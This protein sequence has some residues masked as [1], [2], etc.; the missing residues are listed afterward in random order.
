MLICL[1]NSPVWEPFVLVNLQTPKLCLS[2]GCILSGP[3]SPLQLAN[4]KEINKKYTCFFKGPEVT[5]A[6]IFHWQELVTWK[7]RGE[8]V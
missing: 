7:H 3:E 6:L 4:A 5:L 8:D 1:S 2:C